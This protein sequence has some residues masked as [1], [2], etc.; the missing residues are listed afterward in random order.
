M[1]KDFVHEIKTAWLASSHKDEPFPFTDEKLLQI[2]Q[3]ARSD[4]LRPAMWF[5]T[6]HEQLLI[7]E[8]KKEPLVEPEHPTGMFK[9][10]VK[11]IDKEVLSV[12]VYDVSRKVL[13]FLMQNKIPYTRLAEYE[14][15][16]LFGKIP[17]KA[18]FH[19]NWAYGVTIVS[20]VPQEEIDRI[21]ELI[22]PYDLH[23]IA[24]DE[25]WYKL[26]PSMNPDYQRKHRYDIFL[27]TPLGEW[28]DEG[29]EDQ[30][31]WFIDYGAQK[32]RE[33]GYYSEEAIDAAVANIQ[34]YLNS[35]K[36]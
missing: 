19:G 10:P 28:V 6:L 29:D 3:D 4:G 7:A 16:R 36:Y 18:L 25:I 2:E 33:E 15:A 24:D 14:D 8:G 27:D 20:H 34:N 21:A 31:Q 11:T 32:V 30:L 17:T 1:R 12:V 13:G 9:T 23:Q 22:E 35:L 5:W 26:D